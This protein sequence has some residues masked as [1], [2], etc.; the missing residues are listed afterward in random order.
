MRL[1]G[2]LRLTEGVTTPTLLFCVAFNV[3]V[4]GSDIN[5][6]LSITIM[7]ACTVLVGEALSRKTEKLSAEET[8]EHE[9]LRAEI[10]KDVREIVDVAAN[11]M[12]RDTN[13]QITGAKN[14]FKNVADEMRAD[15]RDHAKQVGE[16][17]RKFEDRFGQM[18]LMIEGYNS[19][20]K[21]YQDDTRKREALALQ[22]EEVTRLQKEYERKLES[23][24]QRE[25]PTEGKVAL[26]HA[27]GLASRRIGNEKQ[28]ETADLLRALNFEVE[29]YYGIGQPDLIIRWQGKRVA[30]GSHKAFTLTKEG[31]R[32]RTINKS[33][34][35]TEINAA[36]KYKVPLAILITNT[37]NGRRWAEIIPHEKL[38]GFER[39]T[40][41]LLLTDDTP[42][43]QKICQ[44]SLL[45]LREILTHQTNN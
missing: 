8:V 9:S 34:V 24:N 1:L 37:R 25:E 27:D 33:D 20:L 31:T 16:M 17:L 19:M 23:F 18:N 36:L 30:I 12:T 45:R 6:V 14:Y 11:K 2:I 38:K 39:F 44:E 41:P 21:T 43:T 15:I 22:I 28:H 32:Q 7:L 35:E 26:T 42:E 5:F 13:E 40:T 29:E 4:T 10:K 3:L